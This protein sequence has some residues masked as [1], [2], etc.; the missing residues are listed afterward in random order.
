MDYQAKAQKIL[1]DCGAFLDGGHY[2]YHS[3]KHGD[4]YINKDSLYTHPRKLDDICVMLSDTAVEAFGSDF[5]AVLAPASGGIVLGNNVAYNLSPAHGKEINFAYA[6]RNP[7]DYRRRVIRRGYA[8]VI[9]DRRIL[10]VDD[11]VTTGATLISMAQAATQLGANIVGACVIC[12]RGQI[13]TLK[14]QPTE[15]TDTP[16]ELKI[17]PLVELDVQTFPPDN[18]PLCKA[19]RPLDMLVGQGNRADIFQQA[20]KKETGQ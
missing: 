17:A 13:R 2:V 16:F 8:S 3:G 15:N 19:G 14:F 7:L 1:R 20:E 11:I 5:D 9:R 6:D 18:C 12:D 10:L 4:F